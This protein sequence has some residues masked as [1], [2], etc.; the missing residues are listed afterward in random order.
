M[1][2]FCLT[3][4][5]R[6]AGRRKQAA[7]KYSISEKILN[8]LG[9]WANEKGD[10]A[11]ARKFRENSRPLTKAEEAWIK[12]AVE[13]LIRRMGEYDPTALLKQITMNDLPK[14]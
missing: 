9:L 12:A 1:A 3:L 10:T 11:T 13:A 8:K 6:T 2:Y 5:E 7:H 4:V 14:L